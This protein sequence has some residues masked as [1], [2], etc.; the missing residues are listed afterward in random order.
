[1]T[2]RTESWASGLGGGGV[3]KGTG[4]VACH[5]GS[6]VCMHGEALR[7]EACGAGRVA[8]LQPG[9]LACSDR[10]TACTA[11]QHVLH[12]ATALQHVV[13]QYV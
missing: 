12:A 13:Q 9:K 2:V 6:S 8:A 1:M 3:I 7:P 10:L 5:A 4:S 11:L